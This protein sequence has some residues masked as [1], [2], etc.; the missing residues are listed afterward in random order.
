MFIIIIAGGYP[1]KSS[2]LNGIFEFDQAKALQAKGNKI[3]FVSIDLR[4]IRRKRKLGKYHSKI[5]NI[6]IY[7]YSIP[8]GCLPDKV[9]LFFGKFA[10]NRIFR[11]VLKKHGRPD[12]IHAHFTHPGNIAAYIKEKYDI[13][14]VITEHSSQIN[15]DVITPSV[16]KMALNAYK[17]ADIVITVSSALQARIKAHFNIDSLV[18]HNIAE[19]EIFNFQHS[20]VS[21]NEFVFISAGGLNYGKGFDT[22]INAFKNANFNENIK[23]KI[24]G[25]GPLKKQLKNL[26][27]SENLSRQIELLGFMPRSRIAELMKN[28]DAFVLASR[29]ETFGVVYIEALRSGLPVIATK[30]GGP[31]DFIDET[32]GLLVPVNNIPLLT[33]ALKKMIHNIGNYNRKLIS[34]ECS[35]KF[36]PDTI[37]NQLMQVYNQIINNKS[38]EQ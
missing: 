19:I 38:N 18:I 34:E 13:P 6:E 24:V 23:L 2:P 37:A 35:K 14:L 36:A 33:D 20:P 9:L 1:Q 15:K 30:C 16:K 26:I 11:D 25:D 3:V 22:L 27:H 12:I 29:N 4:S 8:L 17:K 10:I 32:N 21:K 28:C 31:E 5:N 7:N